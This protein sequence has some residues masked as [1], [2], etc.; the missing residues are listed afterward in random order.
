MKKITLALIG[1]FYFNTVFGQTFT[2]GMIQLSNTSGLEYSAQIDVNSSTVTLTMVGPE[3]RW[4]GLGFGVQ[5]MTSGGDVV[6]YLEY[7]DPESPG[8]TVTELTDRF[9]GFDAQEPG[10]DATG[11]NPTED[12]DG[13]RDWSI[14]SNTVNSGVRTLVATRDA[15]TGN[16]RDYVFSA[17]ATSI[18]LV[19]ARARF[20]GFDLE[21]HGPENRGATMQGLTLSEKEFIASDFSITPNPSETHFNI[22]LQIYSENSTVKVYDVLGKQI[23]TGALNSLSTMV[24]VSNWNNGV[25]LVRV[26][27]ENT[28]QT[29]RFVK[30]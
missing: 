11:I 4:L 24:D 16:P 30:Q 29:K 14:S 18:E 3:N 27:T 26:S 5:S 19:W 2:T 8:T 9:F 15:N 21:W 23:Y 20:V 7:E 12:A 10:Q 25:Y 22:N 6:I 1:I 13:Q 17:S 28:T